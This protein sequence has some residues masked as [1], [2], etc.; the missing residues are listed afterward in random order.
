LEKIYIE[1]TWIT[2][3]SFHTEKLRKYQL[4]R[5]KYYYAVVECDS[6]ETANKIY[7]ECDNMEYE[8]SSNKLDLR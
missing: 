5:L 3:S 2:G 4:N 7:E 8:S 1:Y 6:T